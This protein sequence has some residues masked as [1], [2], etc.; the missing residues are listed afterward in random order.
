MSECTQVWN[1]HGKEIL[2]LCLVTYTEK[3][4][5]CLYHILNHYTINKAIQ[6][7]NMQKYVKP[8]WYGITLS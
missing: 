2:A 4:C 8:H 5:L 3:E 7:K 1:G 6:M